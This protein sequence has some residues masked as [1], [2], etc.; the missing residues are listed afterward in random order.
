M[1]ALTN[2]NLKTLE[3]RTFVFGDWKVW[4]DDILA[5]HG[6][7]VGYTLWRW[8]NGRIERVGY[9]TRFYLMKDA[10]AKAECG[11]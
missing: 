6:R 1:N 10:V 5:V 11:S 7:S 2:S 8:V 9:F 3:R 4:A